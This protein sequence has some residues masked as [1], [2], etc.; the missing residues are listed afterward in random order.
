MLSLKCFNNRSEK[1]RETACIRNFE[2]HYVRYTCYTFI[3]YIGESYY[4]IIYLDVTCI[5]RQYDMI[6]I[7]GIIDQ[8][9][10]NSGIR[11]IINGQPPM[12]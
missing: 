12:P 4:Q 7:F 3:R 2:F 1:V 8:V 5:V 11:K 10:P 6:I 9:N